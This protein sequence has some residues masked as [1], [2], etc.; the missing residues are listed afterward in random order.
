MTAT[1]RVSDAEWE[2]LRV[3]WDHGEV[4]SA[5]VVF[6][7]QRVTSWKPTTI[8]TLLGRL[9]KKKVIGFRPEVSGYVYFALI[10]EA[11]GVAVE[12]RSFLRKV[13]RGDARSMLAAFLTEE[14]LTPE[15]VTELR[16]LLDERRPR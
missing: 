8:R 4:S 5:D 13:Y 12:R 2:V 1:P 15:D 16:R 9:V 10:T 6:D 3:L 7:L 11:E 14:R